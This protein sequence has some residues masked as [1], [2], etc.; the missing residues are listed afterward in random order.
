MPEVTCI[1][2]LRGTRSIIACLEDMQMVLRVEC[3]HVAVSPSNSVIIPLQPNHILLLPMGPESPI[4]LNLPTRPPPHSCTPESG[5]RRLVRPSVS[6]LPCRPWG[7]GGL[8]QQRPCSRGSQA[9][10]RTSAVHSHRQLTAGTRRGSCG[11]DGTQTGVWPQ[12]V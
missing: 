12:S 10:V 8:A 9:T 11:G 6:F 4:P 5:S 3:P 1:E 2:I 7:W